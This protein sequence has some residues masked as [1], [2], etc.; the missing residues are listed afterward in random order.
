[1]SDRPRPA[2]PRRP[3]WPSW[4]SRWRLI[5]LALVTAAVVIGIVQA[6]S[7]ASDAVA[8]E[9]VKS[10]ALLGQCLAQHGTFNGEPKYSSSPVACDSPKAAVKVVKVITSTPGS[11]LCPA[12]TT[13]VELPYNGVRYLHVECVEPVR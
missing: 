12:A 3:A 1:M 9:Q 2:S 5:P 11:P 13:G 10:A 6:T 4:R 8:K 7:G